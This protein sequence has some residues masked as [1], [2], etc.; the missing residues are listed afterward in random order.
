MLLVTYLLH[1][2]TLGDTNILGNGTKGPRLGGVIFPTMYNGTQ[3]YFFKLKDLPKA[4]GQ[5]VHET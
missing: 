4:R 5:H 1:I 2:V 3:H